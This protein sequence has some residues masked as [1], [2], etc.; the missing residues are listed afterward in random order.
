MC[1]IRLFEERILREFSSGAVQGTTHTCIGQEAN[2]VGVLSWVREGDSVVS[3]HRGH[4][5]FLA[6]CEDVEGLAAEVLGRALGVCGGRGGS[7]HLHRGSFFSNGILGSTVSCATGLALAAKFE[8]RQDIVVLFIGDGTFGEGVVY[9]CLNIAALWQ[10]P[11]LLVVEDNGIAQTT[12]ADL[13][14]AGSLPARVAAFAWTVCEIDTTDVRRI[15]AAAGPLVNR[16]REGGGPAALVITTVR[17]AAHSKGDDTRPTEH[18]AGL[19]TRDPLLVFDAAIPVDR[20]QAVRD[21]CAERIQTAFASA[22][23]AP[24]PDLEQSPG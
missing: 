24:M 2:A 22:T 21:E 1:L 15:R 13:N 9:E 10:L 6:Y 8:G 5:H 23:Q 20:R 17:L 4:G 18:L 7:Q 16:C 3:N 11:L 19:Q 14:R 12:P